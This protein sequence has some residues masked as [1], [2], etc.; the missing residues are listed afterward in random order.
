MTAMSAAAVQPAISRYSSSMTAMCSAATRAALCR[1]LGMATIYEASNGRE[2]LALLT[3]LAPLPC[4]LIVDL[5]MPT[6]DGLGAAGSSCSSAVSTFPSSW[7]RRM[8]RKLIDSVQDMGSVIGLKILGALQKPLRAETLRMALQ[9][10]RQR[11]RGT[12]A[13]RAI[14]DRRRGAQCRHRS[15]RDPRPLPAEGGYPHR[16]RA[17]RRSAGALA[18]SDARLGAAQTSSFRWPNAAI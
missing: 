18:A 7:P 13:R 4:L 5:E 8:E 12:P 17:R 2:A 14:A 11:H 10:S 1:E 3:T 16:H 15:R 9:Q 6:M